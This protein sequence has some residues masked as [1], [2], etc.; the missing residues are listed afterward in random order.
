MKNFNP[1][2]FPKSLQNLITR[3]NFVA[4]EEFTNGYCSTV[5]ADQSRVLK[6]PNQGE[7]LNSGYWATMQIQSAG[8]AKVIDTDQKTSAILMERILPGTPLTECW[9]KSDDLAIFQKIASQ[10]AELPIDNTI[11][12]Q[13]YFGALPN[14]LQTLLQELTQNQKIVFLHGDLHHDNI[15]LHKKA[16]R[17]I[18]PKG[19]H[20][21]PAF[22]AAA[23]LRNPIDIIPTLPNLK[24]IT[25]ERINRLHQL[26]GWSKYRMSAWLYIDRAEAVNDEPKTSTWIC[27]L[28][29]LK[30]IMEEHLANE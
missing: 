5:F 23:F 10:M 21:D 24:T 27:A 9:Q 25:Q 13:T 4:S 18:D 19:L 11:N 30:Q 17:P 16:W 2:S 7:E 29:I 22:E 26:T 1:K 15:L 20:G 14:H 28:P 3:N 6:I 12:L 8:G